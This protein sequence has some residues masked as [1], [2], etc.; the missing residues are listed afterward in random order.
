MTRAIDLTGKVALVTGGGRGIG[1]AIAGRLADAGAAV[2]I[3]SRKKEILD[4]TAAEFA[5]LAGRVIPI[6]CH[7]GQKEQIEALVRGKGG[8]GRLGP[9]GI[10]QRQDVRHARRGE[11][12]ELVDAADRNAERS[13]GLVQ[14]AGYYRPALGRG[15]SRAG[16]RR[17]VALRTAPG[18]S[19][20]SP[21]HATPWRARLM[22][23][24]AWLIGS[25]AT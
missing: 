24:A 11:R 1:K 21:V 8:E 3:A 4:A 22:T 20:W 15:Q 19:T 10:E 13:E 12:V 18:A 7:L 2:V 25:S 16:R 14:G 23:S 5:G 9:A 17:S 6:A